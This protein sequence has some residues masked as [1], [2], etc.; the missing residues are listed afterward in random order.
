MK[1]AWHGC[2][3]FL[4]AAWVLAEEPAKEEK[5]D[6]TAK[7]EK[8]AKPGSQFDLV[9]ETMQDIIV[10]V[11]KE[12]ARE[13]EALKDF[14]AWCKKE[15]ESL[16][17]STTLAKQQVEKAIVT[18]REETATIAGLEAVTFKLKAQEKE[19]QDGIDQ[20]TN[21]YN[22]ETEK[23]NEE[24]ELNSA[25]T[26][27]VLKA[28]TQLENSK[29]GVFLQQRQ[30]TSS[31]D[32]VIGVLKGIKDNLDKTRKELD[33]DQASRKKQFNELSVKKREQMGTVSDEAGEKGKQLA[34]SKLKLVQAQSVYDGEKGSDVEMQKTADD[35]VE[36]CEKKA[37]EFSVRQED[38]ANEKKQLNQTILTLKTAIA[39][40]NEGEKKDEDKKEATS[41]LQVVS[42]H[43]QKAQAKEEKQRRLRAAKR[44][45]KLIMQQ[46]KE[47]GDG[48]NK[49]AEAVQKLMTSIKESQKLDETRKKYCKS[50]KTEEQGNK[51]VAEGQTVRLKSRIGFLEADI[52]QQKKEA[53]V[54]SEEADGF[55]GKLNDLRKSLF[56][57]KNSYLE[58][59]K[60]RELTMKVLKKAKSIVGN[61][62]GSTDNT[63]SAF[64]QVDVSQAAAPPALWDPG[65]SRQE[66]LGSAV[67]HL[68]DALALGFEKEQKDADKEWEE[69]EE[70]A[71]A[72]DKDSQAV[73]DRKKQ[74]ESALLQQV[75]SSSV[76]LSQVKADAELQE[77]SFKSAVE[78]IAKL[79]KDCADLLANFDAVYKERQ[80]QLYGLQ[81]V[82]E[83]L[84][85]ASIATNGLKRGLL[86]LKALKA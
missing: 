8:P 46:R 16:S 35:A 76:E 82:A 13:E 56:A 34:A 14:K 25:S 2:L 69:A 72:L 84:G 51:I 31:P 64:F 73:F 57:E 47:K 78:M 33:A 65:S 11:D 29:K 58:A 49:A 10:N 66:A 62:Y 17:A 55:E 52:V 36:L 30:S 75:A 70:K 5:K 44:E 18:I 48:L 68:L 77:K 23:Y 12:G 22:D 32:Y 42:K 27:T 80:N 79:D 4:S 86:Q 38:R 43:D 81:D 21:I 24:V 1:Y 85:G 20:M 59:K 54:L 7:E 6:E 26:R 9:I 74:Q 37:L 53:A 40:D 3:L 19:L 63:K 50:Q 41:F 61:F 67:T 83:I 60:E 45:V 39:A 28:L 71:D 15:V